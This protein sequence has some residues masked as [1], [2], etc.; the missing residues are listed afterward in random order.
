MN[1]I[2]NIYLL[3]ISMKKILKF[4]GLWLILFI[5][6]QIW[7]NLAKEQSIKND[8][9]KHKSEIQNLDKELKELKEK[10]KRE[11]EYILKKEKNNEII[12]DKYKDIIS[13][14]WYGYKHKIDMIEKCLLKSQCKYFKNKTFTKNYFDIMSK[15]SQYK[16][17]TMSY[18]IDDKFIND[19]EIL[20]KKHSKDSEKYKNEDI[21]RKDVAF[22]LNK[23]KF[24][25]LFL[26]YKNKTKKEYVLLSDEET[27][28]LLT[29]EIL[30]PDYII[31]NDSEY[32]YPYINLYNNYLTSIIF[33]SKTPIKDFQNLLN[34]N[35][36]IQKKLNF[37]S[38]LLLK[39][40]I[41]DSWNINL[42]S[43]IDE[44][45]IFNNLIQNKISDND[46]KIILDI[47]NKIKQ[48]NDFYIPLKKENDV[49]TLKFLKHLVYEEWIYNND[50]P[51]EYYKLLVKNDKL[52]QNKYNF[53]FK[54]YFLEN[55]KKFIFE[56]YYDDILPIKET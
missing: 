17:K 36:E 24:V 43:K 23:T 10:E 13:S 50:N 54:K 39:I 27:Y 49:K 16:G 45:L 31:I 47:T 56:T 30:N 32:S 33:Y 40:Y 15:Y 28:K 48:M 55:Y 8:I 9:K 37:N 18:D 6:F 4:I 1:K 21:A 7:L 38:D 12:L 34:F 46:K 26:G 11:K 35:S 44:Y 14:W 19:I 29:K 42:L 41:G 53:Y 51:F 22:Y 25:P 52:A 20:E 2:L 3:K 5:I